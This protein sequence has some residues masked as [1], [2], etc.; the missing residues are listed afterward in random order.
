MIAARKNVRR[1]AIITCMAMFISMLPAALL[2]SL[3]FSS[4]CESICLAKSVTMLSA[5]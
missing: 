1:K 4:I 5:W 3:T 2:D